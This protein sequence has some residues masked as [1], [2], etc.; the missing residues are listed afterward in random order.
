MD[1]QFY[2]VSTPL[3]LRI[4]IWFLWN[5]NQRSSSAKKTYT[6][7]NNNNDILSKMTYRTLPY[8]NGKP[9]YDCWSNVFSIFPSF[10]ISSMLRICISLVH[11]IRIIGFA[12][13]PF[14][15]VCIC[16]SFLFFFFLLSLRFG[17]GMDLVVVVGDCFF[18]FVLFIWCV[19]L[20]T[21]H[22]LSLNI[23]CISRRMSMLVRTS[24]L[25]VTDCS[26]LFFSSSVFPKSFAHHKNERLSFCI[27]L[28]VWAHLYN[29][30]RWTHPTAAN[31]WEGMEK[32][33]GN[34]LVRRFN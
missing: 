19:K 15:S 14:S 24:P 10:V 3:L 17:M 13:S 26:L 21:I 28:V 7:K 9:A 27:W 11:T 5:K 29:R 12:P 8:I 30:L 25:Y 20:D 33:S 4:Q 6:H 1:G 18:F 31:T 16:A 32:W 2:I 23:Q 34:I 22:L